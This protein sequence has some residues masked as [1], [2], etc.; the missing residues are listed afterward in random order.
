MDAPPLSKEELFARLA[1]GRAAGVTVVTPNARLARE[2]ARE[3]DERQS[4]CGRERWETADILPLAAFLE[5]TWEEALYAPGGAALPVLLAPAQERE[6]WEEA[7]AASRWADALLDVARTAAQAM[8]AWRLAHAWRIPLAAGAAAGTEDARAFAAWATAYARRTRRGGFTD[9]AR[10]ADLGLVARGTRLLVAYGFDLLTPQAE[11][12]L[13]RYQHRVC[14][15]AP[16]RARVLRAGFASAAEELEAAAWWARAR[17]QSGARRIGVV[18]PDLAERRR[19][20]ARVFARVLAP[21]SVLAG[22]GG[23]PM[24]FEL[25]AGA[26]LAEWPLVASALDLLDAA[27][28]EVAFE[29][30]SRLLRS[31]FLG[32]AESEREARALLDARLRRDCGPRIGLAG[33]AARARDCPRLAAH[34]SAALEVRRAG[35]APRDWAQHFAAI[36]AAAGFPGERTLDSSEYQVRE[37]WHALLAEFARLGTV[38]ARLAP[39]EALA[40]LRRLAAETPFQPEAGDPPIQVLGLLEAAGQQFDA[41]WVSGLTDEAWPLRVQPNPFLPIAAQKRAGVPQA[42][43]ER[44]FALDRQLTAAWAASADEVVFSWPRREEDR[45]LAPSPLIL[46]YEERVPEVERGPRH[47]DL[48]HAARALEEVADASAPFAERAARG[49]TRLV[50][51][52]AACP[53]RAF[54]RH[55]LAAE[56]LET[57]QPAPDART[58]GKLAHVLMAE[59]WRALGSSAALGSA[60]HAAVIA[61]AARAAVRKVGLSGALADLETERLARLAREWL[62]LERARGAFEVVRIEAR[63]EFAIGGLSLAGDL[64]RMDRLADGTFAV[65][66]Y[67]T[68]SRASVRDWLEERPDDPQL[69]LYAIAAREPVTAVAFARLRSGALGFVGLAAGECGI[70]GVSPAA[71]WDA[72]VRDWRARLDALVREFAAGHAAVAP[73]RGLAT[74]RDCDLQP[75]CRVYETLSA[76][77]AEEQT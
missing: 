38:R 48:I 71:D 37:K 6:L 42:S 76:L 7:I 25:S 65:I 26:P 75:L 27:H 13:R 58:R 16:R 57:P 15:P 34:F 61:E 23:A 56:A 4:A 35:E 17:L 1:E 60:D 49:G 55:R 63:I 54:A 18:V 50:A 21:A 40:R 44:S 45:D 19:E 67:K 46:P 9:G 47:R 66:D 3:F 36:L 24:P 2:L 62:A 39:S 53:F 68:G 5:R 22:A 14:A 59:I 10:L 31:P 51:D 11:A 28:G 20:V 69:P 33:L 30:A 52:Q 77:D 12:V 43:A 70:P 73:K 72:L 64:D 8:D 32:G 29:V 41:L 74:C